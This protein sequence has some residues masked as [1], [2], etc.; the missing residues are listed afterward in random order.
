MRK[1]SIL[2]YALFAL[3]AAVFVFALPKLLGHVQYPIRY[4]EEIS[5]AA[6][7]FGIN[8]ALVAAIA[9]TESGY[10]ADARSKAGAM[11]LMQIMP[12]TG[13]WIAEKLFEADSFTD[14]RLFEPQTALRY[15]CWYLRF[16]F[17][18]FD[19]DE[20]CALAA[21]HAGQ[22]NVRKWLNDPAYSND[23]WTLSAFPEDAPQTRHYVSKVRKAYEYYRKAYM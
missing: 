3:I 9:Y 8:P 4:E 23:G 16:L 10:Q 22:G 13:K 1:R 19:G 7:E 2:L 12:D 11:G 17:M 6:E 5:A 15:G 21:Y 18:E 20:T 14:E